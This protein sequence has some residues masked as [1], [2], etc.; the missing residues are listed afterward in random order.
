MRCKYCGVGLR[1]YSSVDHSMRNSCLVSESEYHYFTPDIY[2]FIYTVYQQCWKKS[3]EY[4]SHP[5]QT[6]LRVRI[7]KSETDR[8]WGGGR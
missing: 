2:Y 7:H 6:P 1:Y 5:V 3:K 4:E 8:S